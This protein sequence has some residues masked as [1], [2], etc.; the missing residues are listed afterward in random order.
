MELLEGKASSEKIDGHPLPLDKILDIGIQVTDAL[1]VAHTKGIVHRDLKPANIFLTTRGQAK[2]LDFGLAKL[3]YDRR[4][5]ME[6]VAGER[7]RRPPHCISPRPG[8]RWV[9]SPTCLLSR[10]GARNWTGAAICFLWA[11]SCTRWRRAKIPFD[12]NT[13]AVIF[14]GILDRDPRPPAELNPSVAAQAGRDHRQGVG[15]GP[16][17]ALSERG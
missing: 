11:R 13:S 14:Q 10:R 6:T 8:P 3:I 17:P 15:E 9:P 12:G 5:A 7:C 2:I 1:D 16:R 4:A